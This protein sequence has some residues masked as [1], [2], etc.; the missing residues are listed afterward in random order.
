M[1]E[2]KQTDRRE[3]AAKAV[4]E[5]TASHEAA[6]SAL[7]EAEAAITTAKAAYE[8]AVLTGQDGSAEATAIEA[9]ESKQRFAAAR[10]GLLLKAIDG[11]K[12]AQVAAERETWAPTWESGA[13]ARIEAAKLHEQAEQIEQQSKAK[14]TEGTEL[15]EQARQHG[16]SRDVGKFDASYFSV[17]LGLGTVADETEKWEMP[18]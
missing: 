5:A 17:M 7:K 3:L 8:K 18:A 13:A 11:A 12:A 14:L 4:E 16:Y 1:S 2:T 10:E 9:A 15:L 6:A